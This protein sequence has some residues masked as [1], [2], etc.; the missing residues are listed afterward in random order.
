MPI[1]QVSNCDSDG[2]LPGLRFPCSASLPWV[3]SQDSDPQAALQQHF[4]PDPRAL[5]HVFDLPLP[6]LHCF[7]SVPCPLVPVGTWTHHALTPCPLGPKHCFSSCYPRTH[8]TSMSCLWDLNHFSKPHRPRI[9]SHSRSVYSCT[10]DSCSS[11]S[12]LQ[13]QGTLTVLQVPGFRTLA[14][15]LLSSASLS[16]LPLRRTNQFEFL[17]KGKNG[18]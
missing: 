18:E 2:P 16:N 15:L 8:A 14:L 17:F 5:T 4:V 6:E 9:Q 7:S 3:L 11:V 12:M 1:S 13:D 10:S